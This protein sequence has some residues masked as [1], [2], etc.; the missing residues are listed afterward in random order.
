MQDLVLIIPLNALNLIIYSIEISHHV[1]FSV[2]GLG[3]G[4]VL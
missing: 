4:D 2:S 1:S 3:I